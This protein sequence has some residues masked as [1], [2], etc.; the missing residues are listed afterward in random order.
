V[1]E[2]S[3]PD[4]T[5]RIDAA[6]GALVAVGLVGSTYGLIEGPVA[7]WGRRASLASLSAGVM[8]L[9]AFGVWER[10]AR[11]PMLHLGLFASAQFTA[12]NVVTFAVYGALALSAPSGA[13]AAG[14]DRE[15]R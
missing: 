6:G 14:S 5:G 11:M 10:R 7:G 4:T 3:D 8:L 9:A 12:A 13:L 15:R 1:P 2:S